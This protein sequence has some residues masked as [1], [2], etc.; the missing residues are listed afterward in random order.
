VLNFFVSLAMLS[1]LVLAVA[2]VERLPAFRFRP[3]PLP[4]AY[5]GTDVAWFL[6]AATAS[7]I[8]VFVFRPQ[9]AKLAIEPIGR[10]VGDLPVAARLLLALIIFDFVSFIVHVG[11]HRSETL[12]NFHKVHHSSLHLDGLATTRAH[13]F[14]N[15]IRFLSPQ[16]ILFLIGMPAEIVAPV[17]AVY[18]GYAVFNHSNLGTSFRWAEPLFVTPRMHRRHH[19]PATSQNNF[20]TIFSV[21]DRLFGKLVTL[22]T[23]PHERFGV[24]GEVDSY[25]QRFGPAFREP[26]LQIRR[27]REDNLALRTATVPQ[28]RKLAEKISTR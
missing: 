18:A 3:L 28:E 9:L 7:A 16:A 13:M 17:V 19:V 11:L 4:R 21:W 22:G 27:P 12:W 26:I 24:P 10:L 1:S 15:F 5:L 20:G 23:A 25:P 6:L 14:E 2:V 8:S